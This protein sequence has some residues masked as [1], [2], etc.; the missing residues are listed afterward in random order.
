MGRIGL[1]SHD[2]LGMAVGLRKQA[3]QENAITPRKSKT[4]KRGETKTTSEVA[5]LSDA[6]EMR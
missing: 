3:E 2:Q 4:G 1:L 6:D 5:V